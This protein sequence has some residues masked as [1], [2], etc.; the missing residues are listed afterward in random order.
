MKQ[1]QMMLYQSVLGG[2][3]FDSLTHFRIRVIVINPI[4]PFARNCALVKKLG[5]DILN[6]PFNAPYSLLKNID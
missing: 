4:S 6:V 3:S 5:N 1:N 2:Y